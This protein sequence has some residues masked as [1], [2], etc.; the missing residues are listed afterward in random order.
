MIAVEAVV[1]SSIMYVS[2]GMSFQ[3]MHLVVPVVVVLQLD[4]RC[5]IVY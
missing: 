5:V 2:T 4:M 1:W 3:A